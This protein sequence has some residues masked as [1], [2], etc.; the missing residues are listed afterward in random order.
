MIIQLARISQITLVIRIKVIVLEKYTSFANLFF[1]KLAK[2]LI[3]RTGN[4]K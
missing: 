1:K 2:I 3:K 4:N